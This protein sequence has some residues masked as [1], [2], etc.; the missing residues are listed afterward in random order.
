[1]LETS[2]SILSIAAPEDTPLALVP[3]I[4]IDGT[5]LKRESDA[6]RCTHSVLACTDQCEEDRKLLLVLNDV[7][8]PNKLTMPNHTKSLMSR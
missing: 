1:M 4:E 5:P 8:V 6:E 2:S 7:L 3:L